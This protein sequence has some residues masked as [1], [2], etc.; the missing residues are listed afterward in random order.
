MGNSGEHLSPLVRRAPSVQP[1][2]LQAV[3]W[4]ELIGFGPSQV[5]DRESASQRSVVRWSLG[6]TRVK[7][8]YD[9]DNLFH[10]NQ[11]IRPTGLQA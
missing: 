5:V 6:W 1:L 7:A 8:A 2:Q 11:N 3:Q 9:P 4:Q 10:V